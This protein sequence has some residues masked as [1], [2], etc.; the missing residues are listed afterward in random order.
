M[1]RPYYTPNVTFRDKREPRIK[2]NC[3]QHS[4]MDIDQ[5]KAV[6]LAGVSHH[7][8]DVY[9]KRQMPLLHHYFR[10]YNQGI[11]WHRRNYTPG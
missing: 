10:G 7:S 6:T 5:S 2:K 4:P 1:P 9:P 8:S 3:A 11:F